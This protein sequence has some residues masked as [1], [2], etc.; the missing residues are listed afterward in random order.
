MKRELQKR[1]EDLQKELQNKLARG[2]SVSS[3]GGGSATG[4]SSP[5]PGSGNTLNS[6]R[7]NSTII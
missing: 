7:I 1:V 6:H 4:G 3:G 2:G 5:L